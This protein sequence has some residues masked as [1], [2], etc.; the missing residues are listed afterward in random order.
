MTFLK[1]NS[2]CPEELKPLKK[3]IFRTELCI[4]LSGGPHLL[5]IACKKCNS[6]RERENFEDWSLKVNIILGAINIV[7]EEIIVSVSQ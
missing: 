3:S 4:T 6:Q 7:W 5:K 2:K 1:N